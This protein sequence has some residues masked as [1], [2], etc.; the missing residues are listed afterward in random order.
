MCTV[1]FIPI[2]KNDFILTSNRDESPK[3]GLSSIHHES[4]NGVKILSPKDKKAGGTWI[5]CSDTGKLVCILNGAFEKHQHTPPY[6]RSRG[7][8]AID[9]FSFYSAHDF[10][11]T[12]QFE[13]MEPFTMIIWDQTQLFEF[14]WDGKQQF[15]TEM[16]PH[17]P[18]IWS[19]CTLYPKDIQTKRKGWF[20]QWINNKP[21]FNT[22]NI[23]DFHK[24]GGDGDIENDFLMNRNGIVQTVSITSV[25]KTGNL[26]TMEY[27][28]LLTLQKDKSKLNIT[29]ELV[30]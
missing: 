30:E 22:N 3:R 24:K 6:R 16:N 9:F 28:D 27:H 12:Y 20:D 13:G 29:R 21:V 4:H 25:K 26:F 18:H 10:F 15:I 8:M 5:A 14:R 19:S 11:K 1:S 17:Q 23:I 7:L 2:Q